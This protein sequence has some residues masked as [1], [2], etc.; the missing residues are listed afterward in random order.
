MR[1][2]SGFRALAW[3]PLVA[4]LAWYSTSLGRL[5]WANGEL[6]WRQDVLGFGLGAL[7]VGLFVSLAVTVS[8]V[9]P[10]WVFLP[11]EVRS[12]SWVLF[13]AGAAVGALVSGILGWVGGD[14]S[15]LPIW[16]GISVGVLTAGFFRWQI[17]RGGGS[18]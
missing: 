12:R 17:S 4:T 16:Q 13:A 5:A 8:A 7:T 3:T 10:L 2:R 9:A 11:C 1:T 6:R 14:F 18:G 15:L